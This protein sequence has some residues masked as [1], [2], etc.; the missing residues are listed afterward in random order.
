M[1]K[2][3]WW[4]SKFWCFTIIYT[5]DMAE[6]NL[7]GTVASSTTEAN[8]SDKRC[9]PIEGRCQFFMERKR[10]FCRTVPPKDRKY[11]VEHSHALGEM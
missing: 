3:S 11:C 2:K 6:N 7:D 1:C 8:V 5:K 4:N 9:Q 10:R